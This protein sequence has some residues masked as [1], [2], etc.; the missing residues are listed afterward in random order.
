MVDLQQDCPSIV[1]DSNK[2]TFLGDGVELQYLPAGG[3]E[4]SSV[5]KQVVSNQVAAEETLKNLH[6]VLKSFVD[7][8]TGERRVD[9]E[10]NI[11]VHIPL[12]NVERSKK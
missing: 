8:R 4:V 3:E 12:F 5:L 6:S 10:T 9:K 11:R 1:L 2:P 7:V